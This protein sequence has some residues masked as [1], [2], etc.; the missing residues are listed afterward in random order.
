LKLNFHL[1]EADP[2]LAVTV[3]EQFDE[4]LWER[5]EKVGVFRTVVNANFGHEVQLVDPCAGTG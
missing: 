4:Q 5:L 1:D 3:K 2:D